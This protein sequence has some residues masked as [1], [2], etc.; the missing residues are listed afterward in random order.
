MTE[1]PIYGRYAGIRYP[2]DEQLAA[3]VEIIR[4]ASYAEDGDPIV[5]IEKL[6]KEMGV[7][8][9]DEVA[10]VLNLIHYLVFD[11]HIKPLTSDDYL[12][13]EWIEENR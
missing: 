9:T 13:F 2:S 11:R 12:E 4:V 5:S 7:E 10:W 3:T 8:E 6:V 1:P